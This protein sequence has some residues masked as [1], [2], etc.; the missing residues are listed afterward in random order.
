M[1][2]LFKKKGKQKVDVKEA[3]A[4]FNVD[5]HRIKAMPEKFLPKEK[6]SKSKY[7]FVIIIVGVLIV[8]AG[9]FT[10]LLIFSDGFNTLLFDDKREDANETN[11]TNVTN[12]EGEGSTLRPCS[13]SPLP[14]DAAQGSSEGG[15]VGQVFRKEVRD[16]TGGLAGAVVFE[17]RKELEYLDLRVAGFL[18][19][20]ETISDEVNNK[21]KIIGGVY[22]FDP[23]GVRLSEGILGLEIFYNENYLRGFK[24]SDLKVLNWEVEPEVDILTGEVFEDRGVVEIDVNV[25]PRG[26][27]ALGVLMEEGE[28]GEE[29]PLGGSGEVE[30]IGALPD[31]EDSDNDGLTDE[32]EGLYDMDIS[33]ADSDE[34]GTGDKDEVLAWYEVQVG[35]VPD[36]H[37]DVYTD[38]VKDYSIYYPVLWTVDVDDEE[39]IVSFMS[40]ATGESAQVMIQGNPEGLGAKEWYLEQAIGISADKVKAGEINGLDAAWSLDQFT[41]YIARDENIYLINYSVGLK[42]E[43]S[44]KTT[45][46]AM[47]SSFH[48]AGDLITGYKYIDEDYGFSLELPLAWVDFDIVEYEN[49]WGEG[50]ISNS[51]IFR[52][53]TEFPEECSPYSKCAIFFIDIFDFTTWDEARLLDTAPMMVNVNND[54][55]YGYRLSTYYASDLGERMGEVEEI[56]ET[57][58]FE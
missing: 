24:P 40:G 51:L 48:F 15:E 55:V 53:P 18:A 42:D 58:V 50:N 1:F 49:D 25:L 43:A 8:L 28:G 35:E 3:A 46:D 31:S 38:E 37:L 16:E 29:P 57:F 9:T 33:L 47:V 45:F 11:V 52:L 5:E 17:M 23:G 44:F 4:N 32:E 56:I 7:K 19:E 21:F 10:G 2:G 13:G 14:F 26:K 36:T 34:D 20:P 6:T 22:S 27:I 41:A 30:P 39:G 12:E 54:Y